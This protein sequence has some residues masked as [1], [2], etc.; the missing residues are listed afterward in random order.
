MTGHADAL[1]CGADPEALVAQVYGTEAADPERLAH[2]ATCPHC[3]STLTALRRLRRDVEAVAA[4]PLGTPLD[5]ARRVMTRVRGVSPD[6]E[7]SAAPLGVTTA[8]EALVARVARVAA[9]EVA[10]VSF[11]LA[12]IRRDTATDDVVL[13]LGLVVDYG[14]GLPEVADTVRAR[15]IR[16]ARRIL[17][18]EV[19][20]VDVL[21]EDLSS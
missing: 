8:S 2:Q 5:F 16:R 14:P 11:A 9:M 17:G 15:V 3:R 21:V 10:P 13:S 6:L 7:L 19:T 1:P 20:R 18:I 4:E 12:E